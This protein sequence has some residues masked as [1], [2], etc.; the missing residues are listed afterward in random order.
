MKCSKCG[1][2]IGANQQF[3][4]YCGEA[5]ILGED[6]KTTTSRHLGVLR[7]LLVSLWLE[8]VVVILFCASHKQL[9]VQFE[10][11]NLRMPTMTQAL[12]S[13][14]SNFFSSSGAIAVWILLISIAF[15]YLGKVFFSGTNGPRAIPPLALIVGINI[16]LNTFILLMVWIPFQT[17]MQLL[18]NLG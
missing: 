15:V 14:T 13:F 7:A 10:G 6:G 16:F 4:V 12:I 3:C 2:E 18:S 5:N 17:F 9:L 8:A 11:M 1:E